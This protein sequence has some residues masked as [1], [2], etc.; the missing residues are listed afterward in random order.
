MWLLNPRPLSQPHSDS[1]FQV[2]LMLMTLLDFGDGHLQLIK[3]K[4]NL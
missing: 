1:I 4:S 2:H 3:S